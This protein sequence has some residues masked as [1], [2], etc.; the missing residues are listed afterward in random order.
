[1][2]SDQEWLWRRNEK[3]LILLQINC[4]YSTPADSDDDDHCSSLS[5]IENYT[6]VWCRFVLKPVPSACCTENYCWIWSPTSSYFFLFPKYRHCQTIFWT[7]TRNNH[8]GGGT[9]TLI[10]EITGLVAQPQ[11]LPH[12]F[13]WNQRSLRYST[14]ITVI[15]Q[16]FS[17]NTAKKP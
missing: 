15:F 5:E 16:R 10:T 14:K 11:H 2:S 3:W 13:L 7:M 6:P 8:V 17:K 4:T 9:Q 12:I 1:M